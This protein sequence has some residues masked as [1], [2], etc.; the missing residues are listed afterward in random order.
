MKIHTITGCGGIGK[1]TIL[2][3]LLVKNRKLKPIISTTSRP[4]RWGEVNGVQYNFVSKEKAQEMLNNNDFIEHRIYRVD[5]KSV[6]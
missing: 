1:D 4:Q 2:T 6:V 3:N 5:R